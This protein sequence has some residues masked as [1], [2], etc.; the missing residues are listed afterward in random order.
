[1]DESLFAGPK[2][3]R[4]GRVGGNLDL[5]GMDEEPPAPPESKKALLGKRERLLLEWLIAHGE[6]VESTMAAVVPSEVGGTNLPKLVTRLRGLHLV[7]YS[8]RGGRTV[9]QASEQGR[10]WLRKER[11]AAEK[12]ASRAA[13]APETPDTETRSLLHNETDFRWMLGRV[14]QT[15]KRHE[16]VSQDLIFSDEI[17]RSPKEREEDACRAAL[18]EAARRGWIRKMP[19]QPGQYRSLIREVKRG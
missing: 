3:A 8:H 17:R 10:I 6:V 5:F 16:V 4:R 15:A 9:L 12:G 18:Q 11:E 19:S 1:M 7:E 14:R 2:K 13:A